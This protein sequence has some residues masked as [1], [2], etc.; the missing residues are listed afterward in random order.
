MGGLDEA[1]GSRPRLDP[2]RNARRL[3]AVDRFGR[4]VCVSRISE[5][6]SGGSGSVRHPH[7][8][9]LNEERVGQAGPKSSTRIR[10][11]VESRT[12]RGPIWPT[13]GTTDRLGNVSKIQANVVQIR[14]VSTVWAVY[15][16]AYQEDPE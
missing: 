6:A 5:A 7:R 12:L 13:E 1:A 14:S 3:Q 2:R 15:N 16:R 11:E 4:R 9:A 10:T 8:T